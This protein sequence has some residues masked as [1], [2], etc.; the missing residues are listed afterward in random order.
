MEAEVESLKEENR[1]Y[2]DVIIKHSKTSAEAALRSN[3][4]PSPDVR[5]PSSMSTNSPARSLSINQLKEFIDELYQAKVKFDQRCVDSRLAIET[6]ADFV[7]THLTHKFG[8]KSLRQEWLAGV[9]QAVDRYSDE[10]NDVAVFGKILRSECDEEFRFVQMQV[11]ETATQLLRLFLR[12]KFPLKTASG[13]ESMLKARMEG[14]LAEE[15]WMHVV[16]YMYN[17][18]DAM[19]LVSLIRDL[20]QQRT[21]SSPQG[22]KQLRLSRE[23]MIQNRERERLLRSKIAYA[24]LLKILLDFQLKGHE[25]FLQGFLRRFRAADIDSDGYINEKEFREL[26]ESME[27]NLGVEDLERLLQLVDPFDYQKINFSQ[28]VSLFTNVKV[29]QE[30]VVADER[31]P[32]K[33]VSILQKLAISESDGFN[34]E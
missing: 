27:M 10:D 33:L 11:K 1:K 18:T 12:D 14:Q 13:L 8:L 34:L 22:G 26:A 30:T 16:T 31:E 5:Q 20:V 19:L 21:I 15:E 29:T 3:L 32:G 6:L 24:D 9:W 23:E 25:K 2:L 28:C 4:T 17:E 7:K